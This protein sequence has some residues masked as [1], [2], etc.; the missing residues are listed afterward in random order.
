MKTLHEI[1]AERAHAATLL[2]DRIIAQLTKDFAAAVTE[3]LGSII[4]VWHI[5]SGK[6]VEPFD[7]DSSHIADH[8]INRHMGFRTV[9]EIGGEFYQDAR[10]IDGQGCAAWV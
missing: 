2:R 7:S 6:F 4:M 8:L 9:L 10:I 1:Q 3:Q 5:G